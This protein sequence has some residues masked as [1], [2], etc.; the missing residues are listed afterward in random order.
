VGVC[1]NGE[2]S[3]GASDG[4][5]GE[6]DGGNIRECSPQGVANTMWAYERMGRKPG[7][8]LSEIIYFKRGANEELI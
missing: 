7:E 2:E 3:R 1:E 4:A 5:A 6:A 8:R